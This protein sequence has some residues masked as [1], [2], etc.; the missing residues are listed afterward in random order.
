MMSDKYHTKDEYE[1]FIRFME[2]G[3]GFHLIKYK[4]IQDN[5]EKILQIHYRDG[6]EISLYSAIIVNEDWSIPLDMLKVVLGDMSHQI[7]RDEYEKMYK[8]QIEKIHKEKN[9]EQ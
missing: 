4:T 3:I 5:K 9:D 6:K 7:F 8:E 1:E 2:N